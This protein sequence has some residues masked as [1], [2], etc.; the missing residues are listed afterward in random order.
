M[1]DR[2]AFHSIHD[3]TIISPGLTFPI[4][5]FQEALWF[6][7]G[8]DM[9]GQDFWS[10]VIRGASRGRVELS[11]FQRPWLKAWLKDNWYWLVAD[12]GRFSKRA[13]IQLQRKLEML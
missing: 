13:Q 10:R 9:T 11:S 1:S 2:Q 4:S 5:D 7:L 6:Y 12:S 3:R 8:K